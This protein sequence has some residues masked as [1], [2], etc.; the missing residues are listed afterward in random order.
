MSDLDFSKFF[1]P[2][3]RF[4]VYGVKCQ[5]QQYLSYIVTFLKNKYI[6]NY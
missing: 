6:P 2:K 3:N 5:F 1:P 4:M